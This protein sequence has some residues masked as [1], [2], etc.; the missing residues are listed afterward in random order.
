MIRNL[1]I[2]AIA[3]LLT[4]TTASAQVAAM[5]AEGEAGLA[6]SEDGRSRLHVGLDAGAG[7]DTNPYSVSL[8]EPEFG[9]DITARIRPYLDISAPGSLISFRGRAALDYGFLPGAINPETRSFLLYQSQIGADLEVNRGGMFT[10][11]VGDTVSWNSDP[12]IAV[13]GSL[14]NRVHNQL[15]AGVG[16]TPGGGTLAFRL[17]YSFDFLKYVDIQGNQGIIADG[18]LDTMRHSLTLRTDYRFLPKTGLFNTI[19]AGWQTYPFTDTQPN[20]FPVT[21]TVG[22]QGNILPK[23]A[24]LASVGYSNPFVVDDTGLVTG[25]V[26]GI[27]GQAEVQWAPTPAT[28]L[29]AGFQR[30]FDPIALYQYVG[31]NRFYGRFNQTLLGRFGLGLNAGYSILEFGD[32]VA[33]GVQLT[34]QQTGRLD[35]NLDVG[36]SASYFFYDWL[37][38]GITN[39]LD[40]RMTNAAD[41]STTQNLGYVRNQTLLVASVRY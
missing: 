21:V 40:W 33:G 28:G 11:A 25:G 2:G 7:F 14:L 39:N 18:L 13:L 26:V 36:A 8:D 4:S 35:G 32:E 17:G 5:N 9:G 15:R 22:I 16:F 38:A 37:S 1:A 23:L 31:N 3:A 10:F 30:K 12:G 27:V 20:A 29:A 6:L 24:G 19:S 41:A 34:N